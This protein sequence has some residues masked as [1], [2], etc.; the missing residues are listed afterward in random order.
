M[1][2]VVLYYADDDTKFDNE[3]EC[4]EYE[5]KV[6]HVEQ[7]L[8]ENAIIKDCDGN[9]I[10]IEDGEKYVQWSYY[11]HFKTTEAIALFNKIIDEYGYCDLVPTEITTPAT[12]VFLDE[13]NKWICVEEA[14]NKLDAILAMFR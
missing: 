11:L 2:K 13:Y 3:D 7:V 8:R 12:F 9:I 1:K 14:M 5:N 4:I 6:K 10:N